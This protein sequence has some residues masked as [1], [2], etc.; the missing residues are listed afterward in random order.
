MQPHARPVDESAGRRVVDVTV[1]IPAMNRAHLL[2][3]ALRSIEEQTVQPSRVIVID[4]AS[5]DDTAEVA[6]EAGAEVIEMGERSGS[7]PA[8]NAGLRAATTEWIAFL[9]SDD[10]WLPHHL[11]TVLGHARGHVLATTAAMAS[12]GKWKGS[13]YQSAVALT[14]A[15]MLV[16]SDLVVTSST[17]VRREALHE[18]GLFRPLPRAQDMDLWIRVLEVGTGVAWGEPTVVYHEHATQAVRDVDLMRAS[19]ENILSEYA[20]R[21]WMSVRL[22]DSALSR[23]MWDDMR[24]A[25]H[26][27]DHRAMALKA[28]WF[29]RR[30][31]VGPGLW[32]IL[33]QRKIARGRERAH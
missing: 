23:V 19:F 21:P 8:R 28:L 4:D 7:G 5:E 25:Q 16:P 27:R 24:L 31:H 18:A 32:S 29:A 15:S 10:E 26:R 1:V 22:R 14:P 6:R 9:D 17:V 12:G 3:R 11:E 30:P 33:R 13:P 20:A 2:G